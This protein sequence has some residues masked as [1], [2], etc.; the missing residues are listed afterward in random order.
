M[1]QELSTYVSHS[2]HR[3]RFDFYIVESLMGAGNAEFE[4]ASLDCIPENCK[5]VFVSNKLIPL[6]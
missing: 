3:T 5:D 6:H 4:S 1:Q 2:I